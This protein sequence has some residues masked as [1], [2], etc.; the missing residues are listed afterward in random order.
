[1]A[2]QLTWPRRLS[3]VRPATCVLLQCMVLWP[4]KPHIV[5]AGAGCSKRHGLPSP[6]QPTHHSQ[7][8]NALGRHRTS[9]LPLL[10]L[11]LSTPSCSQ[12]RCPTTNTCGACRDLKSPNLMVDD[13]F[14]CKASSAQLPCKRPAHQSGFAAPESAL[15]PT[16]HRLGTSGSVSRWTTTLLRAAGLQRSRS[17]W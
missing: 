17:G 5:R 10:S 9:T 4:T 7:A 13:T 12:L 16:Q 2:A 3:M 15:C 11:D 14:R 6:P 8:C 1:M